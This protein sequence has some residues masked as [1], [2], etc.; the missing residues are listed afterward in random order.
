[1]RH[2][3]NWVPL[4]VLRELLH[5]CERLTGRKDVAYLAA[6][7]YFEHGQDELLTLFGIIFR[8][9]N[10][11]RSVV[12]CS[13]RWA[14]VQTNHLRL[15]SFET[16]APARDLYMLAQFDAKTRRPAVGSIH[17]V[18][19]LAEGFPRL[20]SFIE[21]LRCIEEISQ[22]RIEDIVGE[23]AGLPDARPRER[24]GRFTS[25]PRPNPSSKRT[26]WR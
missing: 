20:Y 22:L 13:H 11:V 25:P 15:Q 3:N 12:L 8:V 24:A 21:D 7:A 14:A 26:A 6:R 18:R 10:D 2:G 17:F 1:M 5:Q 19:G 16:P 4:A 9:L 23:F